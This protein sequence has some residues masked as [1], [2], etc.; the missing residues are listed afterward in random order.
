LLLVL[1]LMLMLVLLMLLVLLLVLVLVLVLLLLVLM[2][3]MLLFGLMVLPIELLGMNLSGEPRFSENGCL[4]AETFF[5][6]VIILAMAEML[7]IFLMTLRAS[8]GLCCVR[9]EA[10]VTSSEATVTSSS[11]RCLELILSEPS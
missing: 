10:T 2:V 4:R 3:L 9:P 6:G 7:N 11:Q 1:V 8:F 5:I